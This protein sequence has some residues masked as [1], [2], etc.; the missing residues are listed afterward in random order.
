M[1]AQNGAEAVSLT[2]TFEGKIDLALL[3]I[4]LP[5]MKADRL[6]SLITEERPKM[7][8]VVCSGFS[9]DGP[10]QRILDAGAQGFVQKPYT[11]AVLSE[12]LKKALEH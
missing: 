5:D 12:N 8:V 6:Y 9:I 7:K 4:G 11:L 3:D 2:K 1:T 10:V